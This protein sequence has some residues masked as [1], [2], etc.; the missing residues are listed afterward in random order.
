MPQ[1]WAWEMSSPND[2][3]Y[4]SLPRQR[5]MMELDYVSCWQWSWLWRS[6]D[7]GWRVFQHYGLPVSDRGPQF[8]SHVWKDFLKK[9]GAKACGVHPLG[10]SSTVPGPEWASGLRCAGP[11]GFQEQRGMAPLPG[12][13]G[14]VWS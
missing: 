1:R 9:I 7:T 2:K 5:G 4:S 13:A 10:Y 6:G 3:L 12:G 14:G 8:T 11:A